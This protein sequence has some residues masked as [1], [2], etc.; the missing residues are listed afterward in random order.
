MQYYENGE[1]EGKRRDPEKGGPLCAEG[2]NHYELVWHTYPRWDAP[3]GDAQG[4]SGRMQR[5]D[6]PR[7]RLVQRAG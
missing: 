3:F 2:C 5:R 4:T 1:T 6:P 7:R